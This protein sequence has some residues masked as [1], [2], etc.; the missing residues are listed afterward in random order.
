[1]TALRQS[2]PSSEVTRYFEVGWI[3]I[4][5][6]FDNANHS[7]VEWSSDKF[8]VYPNRVPSTTETTR[9]ADERTV[10]RS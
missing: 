5:P 3:Y 7:I 2:V 10:N 8:P 6:D 4:M 9:S 1:M